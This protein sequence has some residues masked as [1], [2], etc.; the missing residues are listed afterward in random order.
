VIAQFTSSFDNLQSARETVTF[1]KQADG[2]WRAAG[3]FIKP[4]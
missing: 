2:S 3:Y 1:E 4:Q